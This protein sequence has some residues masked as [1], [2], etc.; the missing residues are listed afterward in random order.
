LILAAGLLGVAYVGVIVVDPS[1][2][3]YWVPLL[4]LLLLAIT[5]IA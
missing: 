3:A 4:P 1:R 2:A 5:H